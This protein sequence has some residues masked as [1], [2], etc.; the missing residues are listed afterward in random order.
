MRLWRVLTEDRNAPPL[1]TA[2]VIARRVL[3]SGLVEW[4]VEGPGE[5]EAISVYC[6]D[7]L[8]VE[9]AEGET[10]EM[11]SQPISQL[12]RPQGRHNWF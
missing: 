9:P 1:G 5:M 6:L 11:Q 2:G 4:I 7:V 10:S 12:W 8:S 3:D